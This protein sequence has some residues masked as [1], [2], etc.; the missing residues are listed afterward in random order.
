MRGVEP[1][2]EE[3]DENSVVFIMISNCKLLL[4]S[5]SKS[6]VPRDSLFHFHVMTICSRNEFIK[7]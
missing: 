7:M 5:G 1:E 4:S 3:S 2:D 6:P